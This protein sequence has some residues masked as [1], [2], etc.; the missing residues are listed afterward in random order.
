MY[1]KINKNT[2]KKNEKILHHKNTPNYPR[3]HT[4]DLALHSAV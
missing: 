2:A 4:T 1:I 3:K